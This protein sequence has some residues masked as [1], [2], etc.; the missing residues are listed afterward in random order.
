MR[1]MCFIRPVAKTRGELFVNLYALCAQPYITSKLCIFKINFH[2]ASLLFSASFASSS[3]SSSSSEFSLIVNLPR[4]LFTEL[5]KRELWRMLPVRSIFFTHV[6]FVSFV[7]N[8]NFASWQEKK[9]FF[10]YLSRSPAI[11]FIFNSP[12]ARSKKR[13][14]LNYSN[15]ISRAT[16]HFPFAH[17]KS[18][19]CC[20]T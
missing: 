11:N 10:V 7:N 19:F 14:K 12:L 4:R 15:S 1:I 17:K 3:S 18:F 13:K 16:F 2:K 6:H 5:P 9:I 20:C 8:M